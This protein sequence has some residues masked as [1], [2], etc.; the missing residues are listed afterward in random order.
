[1]HACKQVCC[2]PFGYFGCPDAATSCLAAYGGGGASGNGTA[3]CCPNHDAGAEAGALPA[4]DAP[5]LSRAAADGSADGSAD[6]AGRAA[7]PPAAVVLALQLHAVSKAWRTS[8]AAVNVPIDLA[9]AGLRHGNRRRRGHAHP[10]SSGEAAGE[11]AGEAS[12][13]ASVGVEALLQHELENEAAMGPV[14]AALAPQFAELCQ[15]QARA[16]PGAF[17]EPAWGWAECAADLS[18]QLRLALRLYI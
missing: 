8:G 15:R 1:M 16:A 17:S 5:P 11:A 3:S 4:T 10:S 12:G 14:A 2:S 9:A 18:E 6:A 7:D 13:E